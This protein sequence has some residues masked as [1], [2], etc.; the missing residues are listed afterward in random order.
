LNPR[1]LVRS[2]PYL[3]WEQI[4][5]RPLR[6]FQF[7][8]Y[9]NFPFLTSR[10][11]LDGSGPRPSTETLDTI[12]HVIDQMPHLN[13]VEDVC[14]L[15]CE[16]LSENRFTFLNEATTLDRID[17]NSRYVSH[18]WNYHFHY[19]DFLLCCRSDARARAELE[20][21]VTSWIDEAKVGKSDGWDAYPISLRLVNWI[22]AFARMREHISRP[23]AAKWQAGIR[24]QAEFLSAHL[25]FQLLANHLVKNL[26]ALIVAGL[27]L[28]RKDLLEQGESLL[29]R[30]LA[31][32]VLE[33]GGHYERAP[34]YHAQVL[35]DFVECYGLLKAFNRLNADQ[36]ALLSLKLRKMAS[37]LQAMS[38]ADGTLALFNDSANTAATRPRPILASV[39]AVVSHEETRSVSF[40]HT[41]YFTW[42]A[43]DS[44]EKI[45]VDAGPPAAE[46]NMAHA[47][48]DMLSYEL[49]LDGGPFVVDAG[50]HGYDGDPFREYC[51]ST[52][53]HNTAV[54]EGKEQ[55]EVWGT[56]RMARRARILEANAG[57][58]NGG[59]KFEGRY[60]P[61]FDRDL[62]H[63]RRIERKEN[64]D[65]IITDS[66]AKGPVQAQSYVHLHPSVVVQK[67]GENRVECE[68][69][70]HRSVIE[71]F[72]C[73]QAEVIEDVYFPDFGVTQPSKTIVLKASVNAAQE[74]G[75][76][77]WSTA[78]DRRIPN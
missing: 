56:F 55:S 13:P 31:E 59:W 62:V 63:S 58:C 22:Y 32:Q 52:R 16:G 46:Y 24:V 35:A 21:L 17:W 38:Y 28:S 60:A 67:T 15:L 49:F 48:C 61:Y 41:G 68:R 9:R 18:L 11:K 72:G 71:T 29:W 37:F 47:H 6:T 8:Q 26:K 27:F 12:V 53:A 70:D 76:R 51:R 4:A 2:L 23:F 39:D 43:P 64:G 34:M 3:R 77:I 45:I 36:D 74:F 57:G 7:W 40:P 14:D 65:W 1:L 78:T 73:Q 69:D 25:E 50:V 10:W 42:A 75:Y 20:R 19:F 44:S 66:V 30:E 33:D 54:F 5:Y